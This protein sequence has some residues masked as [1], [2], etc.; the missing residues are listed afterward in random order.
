M[1]PL[2]AWRSAGAQLRQR[3]PRISHS[4]TLRAQNVS[5]SPAPGAQGSPTHDPSTGVVRPPQLLSTVGT[6][7]TEGQQL[8]W[9][10]RLNVPELT[11]AAPWHPQLRFHGDRDHKGSE[12]LLKRCGTLS[13]VQNTT[14]L[15]FPPSDDTR[16]S[17]VTEQNTTPQRGGFEGRAEGPSA[18]A[19]LPRVG[20]VGAPAGVQVP[21]CSDCGSTRVA[22]QKPLPR[23]TRHKNQS[24]QPLQAGAGCTWEPGS[25]APKRKAGNEALSCHF[26]CLQ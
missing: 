26:E 12:F 3:D 8:P 7:R 19:A 24:C 1:C 5:S 4:P 18:S 6:V 13:L 10:G 2:P 11:R 25:T 17:C 20:G 15:G 22:A 23:R 16:A 9:G 14:T 21:P